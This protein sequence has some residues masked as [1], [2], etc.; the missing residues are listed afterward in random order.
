MK[1]SDEKN[2]QFVTSLTTSESKNDFLIE[3]YSLANNEKEDKKFPEKVI[4]NFDELISFFEEADDPNQ[5][6]IAKTSETALV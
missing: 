1:N 3:L 2:Y 6:G 4:H 5:K